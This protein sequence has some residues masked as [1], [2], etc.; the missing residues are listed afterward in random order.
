ML[1]KTMDNMELYMCHGLLFLCEFN[2]ENHMLNQGGEK[3]E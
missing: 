1:N 2:M 3:I